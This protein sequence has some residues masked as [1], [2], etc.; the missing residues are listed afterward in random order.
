LQGLW[1]E[2][3][4][5]EAACLGGGVSP[6]GENKKKKILREKKKIASQKKRGKTRHMVGRKQR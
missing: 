2:T 6:A 3:T 1:G 5:K 4:V